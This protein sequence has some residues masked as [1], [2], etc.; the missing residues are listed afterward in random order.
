MWD[1]FIWSFR[2]S[3]S[4]EPL[5]TALCIAQPQW[6]QECQQSPMCQMI[7][8][9]NSPQVFCTVF[10]CADLSLHFSQA[11]WAQ[12]GSPSPASPATCQLLQEVIF[13]VVFMSVQV[14]APAPALTPGSQGCP[15]LIPSRNLLYYHLL[16]HP[17]APPHKINP[18][19]TFSH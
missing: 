14:P 8:C 1:K 6:L 11:D 9:H 12:I 5:S 19:I 7:Q 13:H 15:L 17:L 4:W 2:I 10:Y 18:C 16:H 3:H